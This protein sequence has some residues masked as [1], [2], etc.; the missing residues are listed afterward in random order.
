MGGE[1]KYVSVSSSSDDELIVRGEGE[2]GDGACV[3]V[4]DTEAPVGGEGG[5]GGEGGWERVNSDH[6]IAGTSQQVLS[7]GAGH[8]ES[9]YLSLSLGDSA[10]HLTHMEWRGRSLPL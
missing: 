4:M 8:T 1:Y 9:D 6:S 3:V 7:R 10:T 5:G 2:V